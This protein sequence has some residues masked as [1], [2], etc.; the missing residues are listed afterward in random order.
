MGRF[1]P[2]LAALISTCKKLQLNCHQDWRSFTSTKVWNQTPEARSVRNVTKTSILNSLAITSQ[3][4][5][6]NKGWSRWTWRRSRII[7]RS[8][9]GN[10]KKKGHFFRKT[11][12][13]DWSYK[14]NLYRW[15][16]TL[17]YCL[18]WRWIPLWFCPRA[19]HLTLLCKKTPKL[20]VRYSSKLRIIRRGFFHTKTK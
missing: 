16:K 2:T 9:T 15:H 1:L 4:R 20:L 12:K 7:H 6:Y 3:K 13:S 8:L 14:T 18:Q 5:T 10:K 19:I 17:K 11:N